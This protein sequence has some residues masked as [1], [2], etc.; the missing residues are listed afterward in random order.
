LPQIFNE[1]KFFRLGE[2][3]K[4]TNWIVEQVKRR[5]RDQKNLLLVI[6]GETG[7]AKSYT[8]LRLGQCFSKAFN[9]P[10]AVDQVLF[11][12]LRFFPLMR[13]LP[14]RSTIMFDEGSVDASE[15]IP[16]LYNDELKVDTIEAIYKKFTYHPTK[17]K[18]LTTNLKQELWAHPSKI[19]ANPFLPPKKIYRITTETGREITGTS[20][21]S[22]IIRERGLIKNVK[23]SDLRLE[24]EVPVMRGVSV[25]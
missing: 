22:F 14:T 1:S 15:P 5:F 13:T 21:H 25:D 12:P 23:G 8:G 7:G 4:T 10:F 20:D 6:T 18:I 24:M 17:I 19:M 3:A 2:N 9:V 11:N 16:Y